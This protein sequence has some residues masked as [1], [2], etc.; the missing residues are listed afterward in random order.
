[1]KIPNSWKDVTIGQ[2]MELRQVS[3]SG[4]D[5]T[6]QQIAILCGCTQQDIM[7]MSVE[8][9]NKIVNKL[10]FVDSDPVGKLRLKF[11]HKGKR[12][13]V[14]SN[15]NKMTV[16]QYIDI[17]NFVKMGVSENYHNIFAIICRPMRLGLFKRPYSIDRHGEYSDSMLSLPVPIALA[18]AAFFLD[19][20]TVF[21]ESFPTFLE[22]METRLT[23]EVLSTDSGGM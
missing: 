23:Q 19:S 17:G 6:N 16:G 14:T 2:F 22:E 13:A 15:V 21:T 12:W 9:R 5:A 10:S 11:F 1:M 18:V 3:E 20:L 8:T 7:K 4:F